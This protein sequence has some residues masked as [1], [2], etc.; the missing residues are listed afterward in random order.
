MKKRKI[1]LQ[2]KMRKRLGLKIFFDN[3]II[4]SSDNKC[5]TN[6]KNKNAKLVLLTMKIIKR[7]NDKK[8]TY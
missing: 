1:H 3:I 7:Q 4:T 2:L 5:V 8:L 6:N